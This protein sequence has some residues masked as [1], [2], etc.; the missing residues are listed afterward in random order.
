MEDHRFLLMTGKGRKK[1]HKNMAGTDRGW[2]DNSLFISV[3][4]G[5]RCSVFYPIGMELLMSEGKC[6]SKGLG[7]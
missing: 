4:H 3:C 6:G 1:K 5:G 7:S 2:L